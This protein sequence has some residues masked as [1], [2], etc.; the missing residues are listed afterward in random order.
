MT[1]DKLREAVRNALA[2]WDILPPER[3]YTLEDVTDWMQRFM[4]PAMEK[5]RDSLEERPEGV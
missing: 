2:E 1:D 3:K 4:A 5:L